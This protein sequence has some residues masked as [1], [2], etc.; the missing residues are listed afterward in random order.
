MSR[1]YFLS[2]IENF[3]STHENEILGTLTSSENIFSITPKTTYAWQG[4]ISVMQSS[5]VGIDGYIHFEYVIPR[6]GKRVD[7]LLVIQNMILIKND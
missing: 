4:E 3:I 6:M 2:T 7:V 1:S 5:L